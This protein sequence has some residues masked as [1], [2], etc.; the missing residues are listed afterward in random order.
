MLRHFVFTECKLFEF[1]DNV[2]GKRMKA[3]P[4]WTEPAEKRG[5]DPL[6]MQ[7]SGVVLYQ[8]LLPGI[9]NVT[10][11]MRYYGFYCWLSDAY[12]RHE[13]STNL[14][15]WR[16]WVRRGEALYA[17]VSSAAGGEGGVGGIDWANDRLLLNET[18]I[19]F[20]NAASTDPQMDR[21]LRQSMGVF[22]G[23]Y[24]SQMVETGLFEEGYHGIPKATPS[25]GLAAAR[26]FRDAIGVE[27]EEL[28]IEKI[29][30]ARITLEELT[31]LQ[32]ITPSNIPGASAEREAYEKILFPTTDGAKDHS[33][34]A[35]LL[36]LLRVS[37]ALG[38]RPDPD[39]IRWHL[40]H[41]AGSGYPEQL[42]VQ[43]LRWEA[44]Q[45]HDLFQI[46]AAGLLSW[47]I[48]LMAE[49]DGGLEF[50]EIRT[51][52]TGRLSE[53]DPT[54]ARGTWKEFRDVLEADD[55]DYQNWSSTITGKRYTAEDK[56]WDAIKLM[57]A[58]HN[59]VNKRPDL[60]AEI[61]CSFPVHAH[62]RSVRSELIWLR[63]QETRPVGEVISEYLTQRVVRRHTWVAMQKLRRQKD[64][65][66]LFEVHDGRLARR[67]DYLP[68]QTTPRLAPAM[69]FLTDVQL[70]AADGLTAR[71]RAV[72]GGNQ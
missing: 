49:L 68:V 20:A 21:Y 10:L 62:A 14:E 58:L 48:A 59:R 6:G 57:A 15:D 35:T 37:E 40:F 52:V 2:W 72:L 5:L 50:G 29:K 30:S 34:R 38:T 33:R 44:Y 28:L 55:R 64:Y 47:A 46:A 31:A 4:Q 54:A 18:E 56:V 63:E 69:Q 36:L 3:L 67:A 39:E 70:V 27:V 65:T 19:D 9:S 41:S 24:Y 43:R 11:R 23:A 26:A 1:E 12:A 51:L 17:L 66:F 22:G 16:R 42:E 8:A 53:A 32:T 13:G 60:T 45:I 25:T 7:N 71:G 61:D